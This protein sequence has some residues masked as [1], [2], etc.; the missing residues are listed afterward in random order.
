MV[1]AAEC[2]PTIVRNRIVKNNCAGIAIGEA[3]AV[4]ESNIIRQNTGLGIYF[5]SVLNASV[6]NNMICG[7]YNTEA[8]YGGGILCT[9]SVLN[10]VNNTIFDNY[11]PRGG[12]IAVFDSSVTMT[13]TILWGNSTYSSGPEIYVGRLASTSSLE[14]SYSDVEGG[15]AMADVDPGCALVWGPGMIDSDP[16]FIWPKRYDLRLSVVS[17]CKNSGDNY[18]DGIPLVDFEGDPRIVKD[19]VDMGAD[20]YFSDLPMVSYGGSYQ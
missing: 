13:N 14:I 10:L 18:V 16:L 7:N 11:G 2:A 8:P 20:E 15:Q 17:P 3:E 19:V 5:E 6:A 4:I 1:C 9:L 12:G